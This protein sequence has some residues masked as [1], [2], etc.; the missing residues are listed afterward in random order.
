[1]Y[2]LNENHVFGFFNKT[3]PPAKLIR[4]IRAA[5]EHHHRQSG[6]RLPYG[7]NVLTCEERDYL[8]KLTNSWPC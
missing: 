1:M 8:N 5:L 4:K 7:K 3:A 6:L 2:A